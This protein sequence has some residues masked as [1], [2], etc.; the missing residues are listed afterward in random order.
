MNRFLVAVGIGILLA[1]PLVA[2]AASSGST[3]ANLPPAVDQMF[4]RDMIQLAES[5][6]KVAGFNPGP[7]DGIFD[8]QTASALRSYQV[9]KG[10][11]VTGLLDDTTRRELWP[12]HQDAGED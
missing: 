11:P 3:S 4:A 12:G 6:L 9:A 10:L 7:V 5:Q 2:W 1:A 8:A